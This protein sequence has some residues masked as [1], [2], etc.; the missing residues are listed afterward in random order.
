MRGGDRL[1]EFLRAGLE[2]GHG[3]ERLASV[4][5]EAGWSERRIEAGLAEWHVEPGM[6]PVPR[7]GS[8][9]AGAGPALMQGLGFLALVAMC[10]Q[11]VQLGF[12]LAEHATPGPAPDWSGATRMR[13]PIAVLVV[14]IPVF[15]VLHLRRDA[16]GWPRRWLAVGSGFLAG[17]ALL[18]SAVAVVH[19]L[20]SGD[21]T[22][23]FA[24]KAAVVVVVALLAL[25]V[26]RRELGAPGAEVGPRGL[27]GLALVMV[28]AGIWVSGGPA[29]GRAEQRDQE[30]WSD[31]DAI[32]FQAV[33]LAGEGVAV[34]PVVATEACPDLPNL[35]DRQTGAPYRIALARPGMVRICA[36][37]E[38]EAMAR[39][40]SPAGP[41]CREVMLSDEARRGPGLM[42]PGGG[43]LA[44]D[45]G[46]GAIPRP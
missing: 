6:P 32:A 31:L 18:G 20:L 28:V 40:P 14:M 11:L 46:P 33:C 42:P 26:Y 5:R 36:E 12:L 8:G 43:I 37:M 9:Q 10:W 35:V 27:I 16:S 39:R 44:P 1:E 30:R 2:A 19:A 38:S 4:L 34:P 17:I 29:A 13:W 24:L 3:P 23:R 25:L 7:T 22:A 15:S 41:G 45:A 21:L